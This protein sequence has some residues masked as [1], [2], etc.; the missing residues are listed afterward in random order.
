M[1]VWGS[2]K[3]E[4]QPQGA[5]QNVYFISSPNKQTKRKDPTEENPYSPASGPNFVTR[6][7]P[8]ELGG[9]HSLSLGISVL[10]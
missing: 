4:I 1:W 10:S 9:N 8:E 6:Q 2:N 5:L 3:H 7:A